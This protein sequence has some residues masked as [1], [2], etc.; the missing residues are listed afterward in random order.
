MCLQTR[1]RI[2][3]SQ[4]NTVTVLIKHFEFYELASNPFLLIINMITFSIANVHCLLKIQLIS[5]GLV[6]LSKL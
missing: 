6:F 1:T 4:Y 3:K 2:K 5:T